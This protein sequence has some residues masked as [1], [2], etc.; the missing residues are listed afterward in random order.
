MLKNEDVRSRGAVRADLT[1]LSTLAQRPTRWP[2][3]G[4]GP[5]SP[6]CAPNEKDA[7]FRVSGWRTWRLCLLR[8]E[9]AAVGL[10]KTGL[11]SLY[12][13]LRKRLRQVD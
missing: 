3:R 7:R 10:H 4:P 5:R 2:R 9:M 13:D 6:G 11:F 12:R 8:G 1:C